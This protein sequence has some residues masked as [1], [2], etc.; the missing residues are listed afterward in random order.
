[1]IAQAEVSPRVAVVI[2]AKDARATIARAVRSALAEP[3]AAEVVVVD[4]GSDDGTADVARSCDDG[5]GRLRVL[6]QPNRGPAAARN[7]AIEGTISPYICCLDAD[8]FFQPGRLGHIFSAAGDSWDLAADK[9]LLGQ[10]GAEDGPYHRWRGEGLLPRTLDF[11]AFVEGNISRARRPRAELGYLKPVMRRAFLDAHGLRFREDLWLGED[12]FL[13][14]EALACGARFRTVEHHG[15]VA[16]SRAS[17]LSHDHP[18]ER[19]EALLRADD[20]LTA[21][22]LTPAER[23]AVRRHRNDTR[24]KWLY[25]R[26]LAAKQDGRLVRAAAIALSKPDAAAYVLTE[27]LRAR[28]TRWRDGSPRFTADVAAGATRGGNRAR[29]ASVGNRRVDG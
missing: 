24:R 29:A 5:V 26:A 4:D 6:R 3:E 7:T 19:L 22:S 20:A 28:W 18:P 15:Y 8:D 25:R 16:I 10:E 11:A 9:L 27:T 21:R 23:Q 12:Y 2:A 17:S 14:A 1:L 13:Y